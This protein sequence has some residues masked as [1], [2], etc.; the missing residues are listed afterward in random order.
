MKRLLPLLFVILVISQL[1]AQQ[2]VA[3][4][5]NINLINSFVVSKTENVEN[6]YLPYTNLAM[7][8]LNSNLFDAKFSKIGDK[9]EIQ[10]FDDVQILSKIDKISLNVNN[11]LTIRT[12]LENYEA[13]YMI[14]TITGDE[15]FANIEIPELNKKY[16]IQS[17][18]ELDKTYLL[19]VDVKKYKEMEMEPEYV[20][21]PD[22]NSIL[23]H[24]TELNI[25]KSVAS[26]D[27]MVLY[28]TAAKDW[29]TANSTGIE[30]VI[31]Q[32][33]ATAQLVFDNSQT[34][35]I[36]TLVYSA[37][38]NYAE[39]GDSDTDLDRLSET[40]DGFIDEIHQWRNDY[41]ADF[42]SLLT[43]SGTSGGLGFLLTN[44]SGRPDLAF[45]VC[46]VQQT[47][48]G[49]TLVHEVGHNMGAHH[50]KLQNY[51]PGPTPWNNWPVVNNWSAG[52]RW[53]GTDN[54]TYCSVMT[55][56]SGTYFDGVDA[57]RV[58]YFSS[59]NISYMGHPVGDAQEGDNAR[60]ISELRHTLAAYRQTVVICSPPLMQASNLEISEVEDYQMTLSWTRGD[61]DKVIILG[62]QNLAVES[63]P[64]NGIEYTADSLFGLGDV[65]NI[66][67]Y[68]VYNG[69]GNSVTVTNLRSGTPYHF[70]VYEYYTENN[71]YTLAPIEI[72]TALTE[73]ATT[74]GNP[75]CSY[76]IAYCDMD[77][78][79]G[80]TNV[81]FNTINNSSSSTPAMSYFSN[82]PNMVILGEEYDL[83]VRIN[84]GGAYY[85]YVKAWIDWDNN[86]V[87]DADEEYNLGT[88]YN[89]T[90][91]LTSLSP[92][93]ITI[94]DDAVIGKT[95][96]RIRTTSDIAPLCCDIQ[97]FTETETY[98]MHIAS[99]SE[100]ELE[101]DDIVSFYPNPANEILNFYNISK[102]AV[103]LICDL[104]GK[105]ILNQ[106]NSNNQID[107][108]SLSNGI[109]II[110]IIGNSVT[111]TEKFVKQ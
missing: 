52:W 10:L 110:K 58:P 22:S 21:V 30:N 68:V 15:I 92:L 5:K 71:C 49:Y 62:R 85:S 25:D 53:L 105:Q 35:I 59:P 8:E 101:S 7:V 91:G 79:T 83:S 46:L 33:M 80:I 77:D 19:D 107:I 37:E 29:A 12:R 36:F 100:I 98:I 106:I 31:G 39:T 102:N 63:G 94:P 88:G 16:V 74:T 99:E 44:Y 67:N 90:D 69:D 56:E 41:G 51:Q 111:I 86:C 9:I 4:S 108:S 57:I 109:Y 70:A 55:Y 3:K 43:A 93:S 81:T 89:L 1:N 45:S 28:T 95:G 26:V 87:F 38:L 84:T 82:I 24:A 50:H 103:I 47:G 48:T 65:V 76:C 11:T 96:F 32:A 14:L 72:T 61:G 66:V 97:N 34:N 54:N 42:V 18:S 2:V 60:T 40:E 78:D 17:R 20:I 104:S 27:M 13:G 64:W 23:K 75:P 6:L 73:T